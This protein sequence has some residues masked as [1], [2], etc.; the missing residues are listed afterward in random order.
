MSHNE[1]QELDEGVNIELSDK[2]AALRDE[3]SVD[4]G[5]FIPYNSLINYQLTD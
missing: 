2:L 1:S 3:I 5:L 4:R